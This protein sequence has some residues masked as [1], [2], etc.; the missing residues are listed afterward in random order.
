MQPLPMLGQVSP[1]Y[2]L[3]A[4]KANRTVG[5]RKYSIFIRHTDERDR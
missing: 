4:L 1:L 5:Q 2:P 3:R